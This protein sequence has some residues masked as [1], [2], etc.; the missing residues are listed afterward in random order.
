M[1][2]INDK[3]Y[4][5]APGIAVIVFQ[6]FYPEGKQGGIEIIQHGERVATNG[7]LRLEPAPGQWAELPKFI[8]REVRPEEKAIRVSMSYRKND[9]NYT[10]KVS[11]EDDSIIVTVDLDKPLE[12]RLRDKVGLNLEI[13]P[14]AYFGKTYHLGGEFGVFPRQANGPMIKDP[15]GGLKPVPLASGK[16]LVIAPE[17]PL[18]KIIIEMLDDGDI[19][20]I[21]GRNT[22][23]NGWFVVR[24]LLPTGKIREAVKWKI[25]INSVPYWRRKPIIGISQVGYHPRQAKKAVIE[26][27]PRIGEIEEA[28]L[29]RID[30][31]KGPVEI[32]SSRPEKWGRF[33]Y[34][35][36]AIFD[37]THV[38][39]PGMYIIRYG[40]EL[41]P[42]FPI[43]SSVY[44]E[45]WRP[46]L[47]TYFP[48]QMCHVKVKDCYRVWHGACHLDDALQAPP[49]HIH[50]DGYIQG[51]ETETP[52]SANQHVPYLNMGGW[53]D[54]GDYDL[55][56]GS[57]AQT[58]FLLA[59]A[60]EEFNVNTDQT[61]VKRDERLVILHTPDGV[62]DIVQQVAHGVEYLLSGYRAAGHSF[63][64]VIERSLEQYVHL[65]DA[66]TITDNRIY[67][68]T[69]APNQVSGERSGC[70]DDRWV[71]T[72]WDT[73][74]EYKVAAALAAASRAL[75]GYEDDLS[76]ES[77][78]TAI[79]I[80]EY[81]QT[82]PAAKQPSAYVPMEP[83]V[84]EILAAV[85]LLIT[86]H[87]ERFRQHLVKMLPVIKEKIHRVGWA[88]ARALPYIED[89]DFKRSFKEKIAELQNKVSR[90]LSE[91]PYHVPF[92]PMI[93]GIGWDA[94]YFAVEQY[95]IKRVFPELV[96]EENILSV[97]NYIHG[98]HPASDVS[99]VSG[100]G[101]HSLTVAYGFNRA[102]WSY[103]PG[104]VASGTALI[105]PE[106]PELKDN[107]PFIWQQSENVIGGSAAYIFCVLAANK[108]LEE[109]SRNCFAEPKKENV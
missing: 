101:A 54:A 78:E 80:W 17:D 51:S 24:S 25:T 39:E 5:E 10:I 108:I 40:S 19:K 42:P 106:F 62:P 97:I 92:R 9:L 94:L 55:A 41:T 95:Y 52:Y 87:E 88:V 85:E 15:E 2:R 6:N 91:N 103:I 43:S 68:P 30:P 72:S 35:A 73:S 3:E 81:E 45:V 71:F 100:V 89:E 4:F 36:Y 48:V 79:K 33:L 74:L 11:A 63:S 96:D 7:D 107:F 67:D 13:F 84:Q 38:R 8:R 57:Q 61:T 49:G 31:E 20:L 77:L 82:H 105:R 60:Y 47:E 90:H 29:L 34:Y 21:D 58:T 18:R 53:H 44:K 37:F 104:A 65:G 59:L 98:C 102:D 46:T 1:W 70:L 27:D 28:V 22:A 56:T 32:Y 93:W 86:T 109:P 12:E 69:L 75:R 26:I 99:L 66:A 16:K 83:E 50:F 76:R 64:G 23:Q 14:A